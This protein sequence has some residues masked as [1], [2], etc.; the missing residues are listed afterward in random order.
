MNNENLLTGT[1]RGRAILVIGGLFV[2]AIIVLVVLIATGV[3]KL[4]EEKPGLPSDDERI[5]TE[6]DP[7]SGETIRKIKEDPEIKE[8]SIIM[9]GIYQ[10]KKMGLMADQYSKLVNTLAKYVSTNRPDVKQ[11]SYKRDSYKYTNTKRTKMYF[12][13]VT[14]EGESFDVNMDTK[15]SIKDID[16][17]I[18]KHEDE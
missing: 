15:G 9:I 17:K 7:I 16:I 6:V 14:N 10:I 4:G 11:I 1:K 2:F 8:G 13:F 5:T 12:M 3:I 18:T